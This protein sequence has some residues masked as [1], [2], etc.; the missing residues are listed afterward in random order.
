VNARD[1]LLHPF[2]LGFA[3]GLVFTI[4][5]LWHFLRTKGELKR[6]RR[7]LD[8]KLQVEAESMQR[9]RADLERLKKENEN[10]RIK[11]AATND[12][13]DRRVHRDL[14]IFA[15]AEKR[16]LISV[17]GFAPAWE[18]AKH[19]ALTEIEAEEEGRSLPKRVFAKLFPTTSLPAP[20][21]QRSEADKALTEP[22]SP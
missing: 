13:P 9:T 16:M 2:T 4:I 8:E 14:E 22:E 12:Q 21:G 10:M 6:N 18:T 17:P 11:I 1:I 7:F 15:R 3:L 5:A 19:D 20:A